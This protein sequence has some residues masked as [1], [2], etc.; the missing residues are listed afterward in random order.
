M[1]VSSYDEESG[2]HALGVSVGVSWMVR[3]ALPLEWLS[4]LQDLHLI[5]ILTD[6]RWHVLTAI[7]VYIYFALV[8]QLTEQGTVETNLERSEAYAWPVSSRLKRFKEA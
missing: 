3:P 8:E 5:C 1:R 7:A 4:S 6:F 2:G